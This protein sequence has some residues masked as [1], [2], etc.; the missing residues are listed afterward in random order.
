MKRKIY[1]EFSIIVY[2]TGS[3]FI[4]KKPGLRCSKTT[5]QT[6]V[7]LLQLLHSFKTAKA[8]LLQPSWRDGQRDWSATALA[9]VQLKTAKAVLLQP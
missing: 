6:G 9:V 5:D 8:V 4:K 7:Q 3:G 2:C 1:C